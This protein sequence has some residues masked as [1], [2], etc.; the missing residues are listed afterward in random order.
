MTLNQLAPMYSLD[1]TATNACNY[2]CDYCFEHISTHKDVFLDKNYDL[3]FKRIDQLL[4]SNFFKSKFKVLGL[5]FWG[6]EP[7]LNPTFIERVFN[8]YK[9]DERVRFLL[10]TNGW[11]FSEVFK[12]ASSV[13]DVMCHGH[14]KFLVQV[15]YD[16]MPIH[17]I[18]RTK[19]DGTLTSS[20]T[21]ENIIRL[22]EEDTPYSIKATVTPET[23]KYLHLCYDDIVEIFKMGR[24]NKWKNN[25]FF[26]TVDYYNIDKYK[27]FSRCLNELEESL[28][29]IS[30]KDIEFHKEYKRFFFAWFNQGRA[31]C[32]AGKDLTVV[33]LDGK[34]YKCHGC[35]Y[36]DDKKD[37]LITSIDSDDF[38]NKLEE[39]YLFHS[40]LMNVQPTKCRECTVT[41]CLKCNS[42]KYKKSGKLDYG[43]RWT[44]YTVEPKL[45]R[46]F[47]LNHKI[48]LAMRKI[49]G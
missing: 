27:D 19:R 31:I 26:P 46:V 13:K 2:N 45:C 38:V 36:S 41:Y 6:G 14:P 17:D 22:E 23:F 43:D 28:I 10:Y 20:V 30:V 8:K 11:I 34:V 16:G 9:S 1:L 12:F 24:M 18:Y 3:L 7:T 35:L 39:S 47:K 37:H 40:P 48:V 49:I 25:S 42:T 32:S 29:K 15:S 33:D 4:E 5:N 21:R 44:D